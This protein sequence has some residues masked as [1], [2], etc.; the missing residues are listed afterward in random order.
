MHLKCPDG[1]YNSAEGLTHEDDCQSCERGFYCQSGQRYPCLAGTYLF[2]VG[3]YS[4]D[5]CTICTAG[6]FCV[7]SAISPAPCKAGTYR[8]SEKLTICQIKVLNFRNLLYLINTF[9]KNLFGFEFYFLEY[10]V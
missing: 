10:S 7:E 5:S 9:F 8:I 6:S 1:T 4:I 2:T 3:G